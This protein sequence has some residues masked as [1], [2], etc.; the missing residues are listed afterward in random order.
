M[1]IHVIFWVKTI[2]NDVVGEQHFGGQRSMNQILLH[3]VFW[4]QD[5]NI[6]QGHAAS[7]FR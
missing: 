5:T 4:V 2:C 3:V 6:S 1:K 7:I